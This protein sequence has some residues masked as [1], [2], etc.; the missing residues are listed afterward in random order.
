M[1]LDVFNMFQW[2]PGSVHRT[3]QHLSRPG[4]IGLSSYRKANLCSTQDVINLFPHDE[5][6]GGQ[7]LPNKIDVGTRPASSKALAKGARLR[8]LNAEL[9]PPISTIRRLPPKRNS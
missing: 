7:L 5:L 6:F 3:D 4:T 2:G 9:E 1:F 8:H